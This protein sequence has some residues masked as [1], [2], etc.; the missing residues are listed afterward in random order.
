[1]KTYVSV[2][3]GVR[4]PFKGDYLQAMFL[5]TGTG[6]YGSEEVS[7]VAAGPNGWLAVVQ[8]NLNRL[9]SDGSSGGL[10]FYGPR[11]GI[12]IPRDAGGFGHKEETAAP[13]SA[14]FSPDGKFLYLT[15]YQFC[16]WRNRSWLNAVYRL[17]YASNDPPELFLG[18]SEPGEHRGGTESGEFRCATSVDTDPAGRVYVSDYMNNRIQ[19]VDSSGKF[20]K[21]IP[22]TAPARVC[23]HKRTAEIF[24]FSY[25]LVNRLI[26]DG[27]QKFPA[28]LF[29]FGPFENPTLR[30]E[31]PLP[32]EGY[33]DRASWHYRGGIEQR[34]TLDSWSE[35]PRFW[36]VN[37]YAGGIER[38]D[39]GSYAGITGMWEAAGIQIL[40][41]EGPSLKV[42]RRF[43]D[44]AK[45]DVV[46]IVPPILWRQR[47]YVNPQ[48]GL[49]YVAEGDSGVMKS[50]NQLVEINPETGAIRLVDLPLGGEDFCFD[51][52][53]L[54]YIRTDTLVARYDPVTWRE[55]P[56]DYG[57]ERRGHSFGMGARAANLVAALITPGHRSFDFWHL[58]GI[59]VNAKRH[60]VVTTCNGLSLTRDPEQR[61]L[62]AG[63]FQYQSAQPYTP[64]IYPGR[65]RWGEI[66]IF[67]E[68]GSVVYEDAVPGMG[69]LNGIAIDADDN[70]YLLPASRR[71]VAGE[72]VEPNLE[73]DTTGTLLKV[74]AGRAKVYSTSGNMPVPLP[75]AERPRRP[76][77][78][79]GY[80]SGWVEGAEWLYGGVGFCTPGGCVCW[81][82]RFDMDYFSRC[83]APEPLRFSVAVLDAEG[84]LIMRVGKYG[85][86]DDQQGEDVS[87][88]HACYVATDTDRRL[89]IA[90]AGN[91][92]IV[93]IGLC[94]ATEE[95]ISLHEPEREQ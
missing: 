67:D 52:Q 8:I 6:E 5:T 14:A 55:I 85:N 64:R 66:H 73:R 10:P 83:F 43:A 70:L 59:D 74:P 30:A 33:V 58:G 27:E 75:N 28:R 94:Y 54:L 26:R 19:I 17:R 3:D 61:R 92:R 9:A 25:L 84:N 12:D 86:V 39:D 79:V 46:R 31:Y 34:V 41:Q 91:A 4:R 76:Q 45:K 32:L 71:L 13:L 23:V 40:E 57:E 16:R 50:V 22:V 69:H 7:T 49:L 81:N 80:T 47:L 29:H 56:W 20:L 2:I 48:T 95:K 78:I 35:K 82:C 18:Q 53:G 1:M 87:L 63:R 42:L 51:Q 72:A 21:V 11:V 15:G 37:G 68:R 90:D 60:L 77:E 88:M 38:H 65:M 89:F 93:S 24:V 36:V 62:L 44:L